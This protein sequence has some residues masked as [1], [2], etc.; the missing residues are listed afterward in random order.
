MAPEAWNNLNRDTQPIQKNK[1]QDLSNKVSDILY[2]LE[3]MNDATYD[4]VND[5]TADH[6]RYEDLL[7]WL[8]YINSYNNPRR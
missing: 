4:R 5:F 1:I 3:S 8:Q 6:G 7:N 2:L